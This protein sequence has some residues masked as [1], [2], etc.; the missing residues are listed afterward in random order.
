VVAAAVMLLTRRSPV[1]PPR[2]AFALVVVLGVTGWA[3]AL[4]QRATIVA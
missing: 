2:V 3:Y 4:A 1:L